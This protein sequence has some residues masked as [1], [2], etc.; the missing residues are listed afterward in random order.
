MKKHFSILT[1]FVL[2]FILTLLVACKNETKSD[3]TTTSF[4]NTTTITEF[5]DKEASNGIELEGQT[6]DVYEK[7]LNKYGYTT[8]SCEE[9]DDLCA[10]NLGMGWVI[11]EEPLLGGLPSVGYRGTF[12]EAKVVSLSTA[13]SC[14]EIAPGVYDWHA[15]DDTI[16]YWAQF[17][18][19][20]NMRLCTDNLSLNQGVKWGAPKW[21]TEEPFNVPYK[22]LADDQIYFDLSNET[23]LERLGMFLEAF[24]AH[25]QDPEYPYRDLIKVI[26]IRGYG[27]VG[28]WHSGW[29]EYVDLD[30]RESVLRNIL[31]M[32]KEA[33]DDDKLL[34]VSCTY[35]FTQYMGLGLTHPKDMQEF[36]EFMGYDYALQ[37]GITFRRDGI[38]FALQEYDQD[39]PLYYYYLNTGLPLLGEIG[40]GYWLHSDS[41]PYPVFEAINEA[42]YKWRINYNTVIGWVAQDFADVVQNEE[43]IIDYFNHTIGYR[44]IP[45][46]VQYSNIASPNGKLYLNTYIENDGVGRCYDDYDFSIYLENSN[47]E[48]VY[49]G[50]DSSFTPISMNGGEAHYF[51][52]KYDLPSSLEKGEYTIKF[53]ISDKDGNP[54]ISMPIAGND[55]SKKYY[56]G[57]VTIGDSFASDLNTV[58]ELTKGSTSFV[59]KGNGA[60]TARTTNV[61]GSVALIGKG[62]GIFGQGQKLKGGSAYYISFKYKTN[63]NP[64]DITLMDESRYQVGAYNEE[65][66]SWGDY[67]NWLDVSNT[68]SHRTVLINVPDDG[69]TYYLAFG[70][71]NNAAEIA[72]DDV[73]VTEA[74]L[75]KSSFRIDPTYTDD[76]KDGS[77]NILSTY[78]KTWADGLQL[79][80]ALH[81]HTTYMITFEAKTTTEINNGAFFYVAFTDNNVDYENKYD[82]I[83][84]F[85]KNR[86]GSFYLPH[87]CG[88][89]KYS[90]LFNTDDFSREDYY[91]AFGVYGIGGVNIK[92]IVITMIDSD[93]SYTTDDIVVEHNVKPDKKLS[94]EVGDTIYENF[95]AGFFNGGIM[96]P[97]IKSTG[98]MTS[99]PELVINGKYSAYIDNSI[100][101]APDLLTYYYN[102]FLNS[103]V[104]DFKLLC[105]QSYRVEFKIRIVKDCIQEYTD[106]DP[107]GAYFYFIA[108]EEGTYAHDRGYFAFSHA[109]N[110]VNENVMLSDY[111]VGKVYT[112]ETEFTTVEANSYVTLQFG[113]GRDGA[114]VIDDIV[115]TRVDNSDV[116][117]HFGYCDP[118]FPEDKLDVVLY[119]YVFDKN[120]KED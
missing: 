82:A 20:F 71:I 91:L 92:N 11:L 61:D 48:V 36:C 16:A 85:D 83:S 65:D 24:A 115:I 69:K 9:T 87:E 26:E 117:V 97:G 47:G 105:G 113:V 45:S 52:F 79:R 118:T 43:P 86:I 102:I 116:N 112:V 44:F 73:I 4:D 55:G 62:D 75:M 96:Y 10:D 51:N 78:V 76:Y 31:K 42:L 12:P 88:Y 21:L 2:V 80:E 3:Q 8:V 7:T 72:I 33:W 99:D 6:I 95:E 107:Y 37:N 74:D 64:L 120:K 5:V 41:S 46:I 56:L 28:E 39:F 110:R 70:T 77:Y 53:A 58:D 22:L 109:P 14:F 68:V 34:V 66:G 60:L 13:W 63:K 18:K 32:W 98:I 94:L 30:Q 81:P 84:A 29:N 100:E 59:A 1:F 104:K 67:Y 17:N 114:V 19:E 35:E 50:T 25:Y 27:M 40:D 103:N 90:Y 108:R 119:D 15:M 23:Y 101:N 57:K 111:E 106:R 38:A 93:Y 89:Q 54:Q 49:R